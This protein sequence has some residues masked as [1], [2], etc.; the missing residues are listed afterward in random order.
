MPDR[1]SV[2]TV[3]EI[4]CALRDAGPAPSFGLVKQLAKD[5]E[6]T[7]QT[8]YRHKNRVL[9]NTAPKPRSGGAQRI[10]TP[11]MEQALRMVLDKEPWWYQ[12]ELADFLL[13][14]Y[15]IQVDRSTIARA[16]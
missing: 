2:A 11:Q 5:Y 13:D 15:G 6:T 10:I 7:I 9:A 1:L 3:A 14:V 16:L 8:I 12:D 4:E